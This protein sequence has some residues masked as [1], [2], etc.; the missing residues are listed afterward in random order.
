[1][2]ILCI[3]RPPVKP[4]RNALRSAR[5]FGEGIVPD[6]SDC[7]MPYTAADLQWAVGTSPFA[8]ERYDVIGPS[9]ANLDAL[10]ISRDASRIAREVVLHLS[11]LVRARVEVTLEMQAENPDGV[12][13]H[14]VRSISENCRTLRSLAH[15][16]EET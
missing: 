11:G 12:P 3:A 6:R 5:P 16:F 13:D 15:G 14:I 8:D 7:R 10:R 2:T 4:T 1:M 9:D